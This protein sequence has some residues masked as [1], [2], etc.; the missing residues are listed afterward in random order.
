MLKLLV[1]D[2]N[3]KNHIIQDIENLKKKF[4]KLKYDDIINVRNLI[5]AFG[6]YYIEALGEADEL[7][8]K[9]VIKNM[10]MHV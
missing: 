1:K 3:I 10:H 2:I 7:C 6:L 9:L 5:D 8:A 4:I